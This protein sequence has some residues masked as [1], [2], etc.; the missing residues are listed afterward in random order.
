MCLNAAFIFFKLILWLTFYW[1]VSVVW[2]RDNI[3]PSPSPY[4]KEKKTYV[5]FVHTWRPPTTTPRITLQHL[6][7]TKDPTL[8]LKTDHSN[9][10][11]E[12]AIVL[13]D[14]IYAC[15]SQMVTGILLWQGSQNNHTIPTHIQHQKAM[16]N[17]FRETLNPYDRCVRGAFK[18]SN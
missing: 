5:L 8:A 17:T 13:H 16:K 3:L 12:S 4:R 9:S 18:N 7:N 11:I 10:L 6:Q 2:T 15:L 1:Y 14:E